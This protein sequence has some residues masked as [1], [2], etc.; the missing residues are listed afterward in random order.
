MAFD[1]GLGLVESYV[2][3][4]IEHLVQGVEFEEIVVSLP[5]R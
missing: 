1:C 2:A 5:M 4:H 3:G